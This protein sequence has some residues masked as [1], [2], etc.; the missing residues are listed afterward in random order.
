[1]KKKQEQEREVE[2]ITVTWGGWQKRLHFTI[3]KGAEKKFKQIATE[4]LNGIG[5]K[6]KD[7][8]KFLASAIEVFER[9]GFE[10]FKS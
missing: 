9:H 10:R 6:A 2:I 5:D 1:M 4:E 8:P 3:L 7:W